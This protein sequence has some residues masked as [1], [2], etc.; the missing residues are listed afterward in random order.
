M[1]KGINTNIALMAPYPTMLLSE[2][3]NLRVL[4]QSSENMEPE[5]FFWCHRSVQLPG[6]WAMGLAS[7]RY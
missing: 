4:L 5:Q 7:E 3:T 2:N 6:S 1:A